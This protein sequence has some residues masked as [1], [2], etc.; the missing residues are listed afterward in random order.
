[1]TRTGKVL[2]ISGGALGLVIFIGILGNV[3]GWFGGGESGEPVEMA[4]AERRTIVQTVT[5]S[6]RIEPETEVKLSPDVSGEIIELTVKEGDQVMA[7]QVLARIKPDLYA[8][9]IDQLAAG[10]SQSVAGVSQSQ[11]AVSQAE[12]GVASAQANLER[13]QREFERMQQLHERGLVARSEYETAQAQLRAQ[14]AAVSQAQASLSQARAGVQASRYSVSGARARLGEAQNQLSRTTIVAPMS[15]TV[16][17]LNVELGERVVGTSQ[18]AGT[19]ILRIAQLE[20]MELVVDVNENDIVNVAVGDSAKVEVDAYPDRP[21][22]GVVTEIAQSSRAAGGALGGQTGQQVTNF[23]VRVRVTTGGGSAAQGGAAN[24]EVPAPPPQG[25]R[26][27]PGMSGTVDIYTQTARNAVA[28]PLSA[29]TVRD[30]NKVREDSLRGAGA[31]TEPERPVS[32]GAPRP[33]RLRKVVFVVRDG[34]TVLREVETGIDDRTYVQI[35]RG[36]QPGE[37]VVSGPYSA[38]SRALRPGQAVREE[39]N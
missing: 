38:V 28:I 35:T 21:L 3:L 36:L 34:K 7:G 10:V 15:G 9:Q 22:P 20:A 29:V 16:S 12:A 5:A 19:E 1:M 14:Q 25:V 13:T 27:R 2:T 31:R 37:T 33:E 30:L 24:P 11:A 17:Q 26:L 39:R 32:A 4:K 8:S 18:M 6:G 23:Q